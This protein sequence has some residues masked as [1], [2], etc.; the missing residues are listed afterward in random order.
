VSD[1]GDLPWAFVCD[2]RSSTPVG[3]GAACQFGWDCQPGLGCLSGFCRNYC[4]IDD[5]C[6][7]GTC[8]PFPLA[9]DFNDPPG[10]APFADVKIC[11]G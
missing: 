1:D 2:Q 11:Q 10:T 3:V 5:D 7:Q 8:L 6:A 4:D 9:N